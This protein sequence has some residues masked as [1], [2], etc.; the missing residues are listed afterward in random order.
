MRPPGI[1]SRP[2]PAGIAG[3]VY[4]RR[5]SEAAR[6]AGRRAQGQRR[7]SCAAAAAGE[8]PL[9]ASARCRRRRSSST[10]SPGRR[11]V[12]VGKPGSGMGGTNGSVN[13]S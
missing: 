12:V 10:W 11:R 13:G 5:V 2:R 9:A 7:E 4:R 3:R 6:E 1:A 8:G